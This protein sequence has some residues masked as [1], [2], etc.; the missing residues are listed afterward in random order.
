MAQ[1]FP[2]TKILLVVDSTEAG[3]KAARYAIDLAKSTGAQLTAASVVD[4][5]TLRQ[6][7]S[8]RILV[9]VEMEE[10]EKELESSNRR[11]IEEVERM[12]KDKDV[13]LESVQLKGSVHNTIVA[14]QKRRGSDLVIIGGFKS[15]VISKDLLARERQLIL[16]AMPCPVLV[17]K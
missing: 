15:S 7:L 12:A 6:L 14:E 11:Y 9:T 8:K 16:D 10:F 13:K 5:E 1:R 4:T 17:I 2:M 3:L